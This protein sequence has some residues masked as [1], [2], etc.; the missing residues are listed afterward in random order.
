MQEEAK[1]QI[2]LLRV[3]GG[4]SVNNFLMQFQ[5][6]VLDVVVERPRVTETTAMGAAFLAGLGCGLWSDL[7]MIS[8]TWERE[9]QFS[10][11]MSEAQRDSLCRGWHRAVERSLGWVEE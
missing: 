5:A 11:T 7:D 3:D 1:I 10:P 8:G 6:D 9:S 4:A 2:P